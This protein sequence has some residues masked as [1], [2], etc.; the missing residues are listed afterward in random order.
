MSNVSSEIKTVVGLFKGNVLI[1]D[2]G[3]TLSCLTYSRNR[4]VIEG[5]YIAANIRPLN[6]VDWLIFQYFL[7]SE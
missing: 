7:L 1:L 4:D 6:E 3:D 5:K 2:N